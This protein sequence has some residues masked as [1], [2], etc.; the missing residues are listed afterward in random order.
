MLAP[1]LTSRTPALKLI[2]Y[3]RSD[4]KGLSKM[5]LTIFVTYGNKRLFG[6][7]HLQ[8]KGC[9]YD[10]I[11]SFVK[12]QKTKFKAACLVSMCFVFFNHAVYLGLI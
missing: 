5:D 1:V 12:R 2:V 3:V 10:T 7:L 9:Q 11:K 8:E 4:K 6:H